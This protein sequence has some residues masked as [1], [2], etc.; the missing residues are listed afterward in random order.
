MMQELKAGTDV[1]V[2]LGTVLF[3]D[4]GG[5]SGLMIRTAVYGGGWQVGFF[6]PDQVLRGETVLADLTYSVP[7]ATPMA[8]MWLTNWSLRRVELTVQ[9]G[10]DTNP[11]RPS[12]GRVVD[13]VDAAMTGCGVGDLLLIA[14][15]G[16]VPTG[17]LYRVEGGWLST[18]HQPK[19]MSDREVEGLLDWY[20]VTLLHRPAHVR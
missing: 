12:H 3:F 19:Y 14:A 15:E 10:D 5:K 1:D 16:N 13:A 4:D 17:S 6:R 2:V 20:D 9:R 11:A 7:G 18:F 8:L